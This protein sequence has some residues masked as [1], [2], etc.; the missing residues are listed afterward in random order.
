M[1]KSEAKLTLVLEP[2]TR[3]ELVEWAKEEDRPMANLLRRIVVHALAAN[4]QR[5][6]RQHS[7]A[8]A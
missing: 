2:S 6:Q 3:D 8:V 4:R 1:A 7:E 5:R